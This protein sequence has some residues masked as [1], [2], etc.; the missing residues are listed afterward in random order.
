MQIPENTNTTP[1][2][3]FLRFISWSQTWYSAYTYI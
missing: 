3:S 2:L 1:C